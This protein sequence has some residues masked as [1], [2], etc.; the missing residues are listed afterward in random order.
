[1][2]QIKSA[3]RRVARSKKQRKLNDD[4]RTKISKVTKSIAKMVPKKAAAKFPEAQSLIAKAAKKGVL[5]KK[6][7]A[8]RTSRM[9]KKM[10]K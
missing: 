10:V 8:R 5:H 4:L 9:A 6:T 1:M 7:A 3:I 2:P